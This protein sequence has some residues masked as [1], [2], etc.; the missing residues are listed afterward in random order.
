MSCWLGHPARCYWS[1]SPAAGA[2]D[3]TGGCCTNNSFILL[4]MQ[5]TMCDRWQDCWAHACCRHL[6]LWSSCCRYRQ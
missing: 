4:Q 6:Q 1:A 2:Q 5:G 3:K